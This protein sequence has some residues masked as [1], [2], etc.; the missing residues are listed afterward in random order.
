MPW[1]EFNQSFIWSP[2]KAVSTLYKKGMV[3]LVTTPCAEKAIKS[4]AGKK[5]KRPNNDSK[6]S[7]QTE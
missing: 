1:I 4:G 2:I 7:R 3:C 5:V 6:K